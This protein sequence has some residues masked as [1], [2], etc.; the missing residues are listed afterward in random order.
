MSAK[1]KGEEETVK[2]PEF[3]SNGYPT[4]E[5]LEAIREWGYDDLPGLLRF[6]HE[7]E[8][9]GSCSKLSADGKKLSFSCG[10]WSGNEEVIEALQANRYAWMRLYVSALGGGHY[11]FTAGSG[12]EERRRWFEW[13]DQMIALSEE[14]AQ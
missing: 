13:R 11:L 8:Y 6:V 12:D 5:T 14:V 7:C 1:A 10:G 4:E 3:D 2:S 9:Y